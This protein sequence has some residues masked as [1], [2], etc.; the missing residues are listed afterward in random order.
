VVKSAKPKQDLRFDVP[1]IGMHTIDVLME[2]GTKVLAIEARKTLML[3]KDL[4]IDKSD[5]NGICIVAWE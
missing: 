5:E 3:D 1:V 4:C 2:T